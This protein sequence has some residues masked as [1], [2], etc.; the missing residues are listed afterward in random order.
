MSKLY[1]FA[2]P[3]GNIGDIS[4][5]FIESI[6]KIDILFCEDTRVSSK[7]LSLLN[8]KKDIE[9]I[10]YHK[11]N[12]SKKLDFCIK[13]IKNKTCGLI[14]DAGY[15]TISDPGYLLI[16]ECYKNNINV[17][18][19]NGPS[20][21]THALSQCGFNTKNFIFLGF[22]E[23][24]EKLILDQIKKALKNNCP[25]VFFESV[26]RINKTIEIL[27]KLK[28]NNMLYIGR[29]L[30]KKFETVTRDNLQNIKEQY[31]K[32]EFVLILD[33][34]E[35]KNFNYDEFR[36]DFNLLCELGL[37]AKDACKYISYKNKN[38]SANDI[39]NYFIK[40]KICL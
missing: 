2:S 25:I 37:K 26:H 5:N 30:T 12:E 20:S 17:E 4:N 38:V 32:G 6:K 1:V 40:E 18:I 21:I 19:I 36:D 7:L 34:S 24:S 35:N 11:F 23:R 28:I 9:F 15:P 31:E 14:S 8:I 13:M 33:N 39:Y 10:S 27:K 22:L 3:I 16:D 29:E